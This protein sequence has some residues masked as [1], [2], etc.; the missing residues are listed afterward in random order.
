MVETCM[1]FWRLPRSTERNTS[2]NYCLFPLSNPAAT[3]AAPANQQ[4][5]LARMRLPERG[6]LLVIR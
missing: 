1:N 5:V 2:D 6:L 4:T 3:I